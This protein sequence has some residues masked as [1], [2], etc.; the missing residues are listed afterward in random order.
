MCVHTPHPPDETPGKTQMEGPG[1]KPP[2]RK[3]ISMCIKYMYIIYIEP[4]PRL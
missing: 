1:L 3:D 2:F 4:T